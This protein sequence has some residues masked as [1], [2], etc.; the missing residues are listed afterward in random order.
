MTTAPAELPLY[1]DSRILRRHY[2]LSSAEIDRAW[3]ALPTYRIGDGRKVKV[4]RDELEAWLDTFRRT[5]A[6]RAA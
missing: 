6:E 2:G 5:P 1:L 4:R 3:Q